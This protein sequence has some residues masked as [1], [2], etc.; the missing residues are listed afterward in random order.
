MNGVNLLPDQIEY[1]AGEL[2]TF[3]WEVDEGV[4]AVVGDEWLVNCFD[5]EVS[6]L[7]WQSN[8][9]FRDDPVSIVTSEPLGTEDDGWGT[10]PASFPIPEGAPKGFYTVLVEGAIF[11]ANG[12][13]LGRQEFDASF[14]VVSDE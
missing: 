12:E 6:Q 3:R 4:E 9:V 10:D 14:L 8:R 5:G 7:A 11:D 1:S 2:A 13:S